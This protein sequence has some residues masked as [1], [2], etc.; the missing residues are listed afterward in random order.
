MTRFVIAETEPLTLASVRYLLA[1][2]C[3]I[4]LGLC[5]GRKFRVDLRDRLEVVFAARIF[6]TASPFLV[7]R[8]EET[9]STR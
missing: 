2:L 4:A 9:T 6:F 1:S 5:Q 7:V 3:L 8:A